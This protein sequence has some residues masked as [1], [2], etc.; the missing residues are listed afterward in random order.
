MPK[1]ACRTVATYGFSV[2]TN[3][4][5]RVVGHSGAFIGVSSAMQIYLDKGYTLV[6]LSNRDF[7]SEPVVAMADSL[8][9]RL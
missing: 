5:G 8:L 9:S 3:S 4:H 2:Q 1:L 6:V 7:A